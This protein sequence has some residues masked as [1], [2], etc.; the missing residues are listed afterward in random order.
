MVED[1]DRMNYT[2]TI[3]RGVVVFTIYRS[4]LIEVKETG[5]GMVFNLKEGLHIVL[6]DMGMPPETKKAVYNSVN[7]FSKANVVVDL[8][9]YVQPVSVNA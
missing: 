9:N 6:T 8:T 7:A 3:K 2:I 1:K 5:D 4:D